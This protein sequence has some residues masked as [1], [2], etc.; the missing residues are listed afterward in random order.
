MVLKNV[1]LVGKLAIAFGLMMLVLVMVNV[2]T[3]MKMSRIK[4]TI[5]DVSKVRLPAVVAI[6]EIASKT[7]AFRILELRH[8]SADNLDQM[9]LLEQR[10]RELQFE[11]E[12]NQR[13][14]E[15]LL[16]GPRDRSLYR[17]VV[18]QWKSYVDLNKEFLKLS[19][20]GKKSDAA[21]LLNQEAGTLYE[22]L[23]NDLQA[24]VQMNR[25][26]SF[27]SAAEAGDLH[28]EIRFSLVALVLFSL[29]IAALA[30]WLLM[31]AIAEPVRRLDEA[32]RQ[33]ASG[34][35]QVML[36][37][38][39]RDEIGN[40]ARSFNLMTESIRKARSEN[41]R[42]DWIK[43][44]E[45]QLNERMRGDQDLLTL[46]RNVV[47]FLCQYTSAQ[48]GALYVWDAKAKELRLQASYAF[49]RRKNL[50]ASIKLGQ[51]LVGQAALERTI[52][53]ISDIPP[54]YV[55]VSSA[56]GEALP[57]QVLAS[58]FFFEEKLHGV[59]ELATLGEF[60]DK[61]LELLRIVMEN[62]AISFHSAQTNA[63]IK[64]LLSESQRQAAELQAQQQELKASNEELESQ[65]A[66]LKKSEAALQ[67][68]QDELR[69]TNEELEEKTNYLERQKREITQKNRALEIAREDI[70][71]KAKE[72]E[73]TSRY[74][75][76]FLANMSHEL[77][78]PLNSLLILARNLAENRGKNLN[79]EQI[80]SA[81]I[82]HQS[83][84]D[85]LQLINDILDLSKIEAG[86]M[87]I[88]LEQVYLEETRANLRNV[89]AHMV[90]EKGL[91]LDIEL[92]HGVP[93][94]ITTDKQRF[95]QVLKNLVS[96]AIKFTHA[97]GV[98]IRFFRPM[99][100]HRFR[101]P[102][103]DATK[104]LG[105]SVSDTGIG[106]PGPKQG[107][108]FEAF[109]QADGSTSRKYGGTG[110]GLSISRQIVKIFQGE[111][112]LESQEGKGSTFTVFLPVG[113]PEA[114]ATPEE[115]LAF[116]PAPER[117]ETRERP[118][119]P[120]AGSAGQDEGSGPVEEAPLVED[121]RR[122]IG[123]Q[124]RVILVVE[125]DKLFSKILYRQC[126][127][128]GFKCIVAARGE[129]G[130][131]LAEKHLP[132]AIILDLKLPGINGWKVLEA[133][134]ENPSVRHIPVHVMSAEEAKVDAL[135]KGAIGFLTK[136]IDKNQLE[137]AFTRLEGVI[138]KKIKDLLVVEDNANMRKAIGM[139]IGNGDVKTTE[140]ANGKE[141][142][143][144]LA[145]ESFDCV[146]L[147]LG[148]PDMD[149][150]E[151]LAQ[152]RARPGI[153][154]PPIIVY[155]GKDITAEQH[156]E[157]QKYADS[158]IIKGAK[159]EERLLDETALFLHRV[160]GNLPSDKQ[161]VIVNL[162]DKDS[163]F[164]GKRILLV[165]DDMR[166]VFA[167]AKVLKEKGMEVIKAENGFKALQAL[168][169]EPGIHLVLMDVMMPE[170]DGLETTRRIRSQPA[171]RK[172]PIIAVTAKAM[173]EDRDKCLAAG[174]SDYLPKPVDVDRL[175]SLMRVWL[176]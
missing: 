98:S 103:I 53:Q 79:P 106:I 41:E 161:Q 113:K 172:L 19:R 155:T 159:S 117:Q 85:L 148:L 36:Q 124:D 47:Q 122:D 134:K 141:A 173:K 5:D 11:V 95:E 128:K 38:D 43:S 27:E 17:G 44:G 123:P 119:L 72:L 138:N 34:Q 86:K 107:A 56:L 42:L 20:L 40:L 96:N 29:L 84:Q 174:A 25:Q 3:L 14:Y 135:K 87:S 4:D 167:L 6:T 142:L 145:S 164:K 140:A 93:P 80:E 12:N 71:K 105:I 118:G 21:Y 13:S 52:I 110:L 35:S 170:M 169:D 22:S 62:I 64:H 57:R 74:K 171:H 165:D 115:N 137:Q 149:G 90:A 49:N 162:H 176:Y 2:F 175:F 133:L 168:E 131:A 37:V 132:S 156:Q 28:G 24:L 75:S 1:K 111:I 18:E 99:A 121:D 10:M 120:E 143:E 70:E 100:S 112:Q 65:A 158:I 150:M 48:I 151:L 101:D 54:D 50:N 69:A 129:E 157:L 116:A 8:A 76:E 9:G 33:V 39:S 55:R 126:R 97:G 23:S 7:S 108:I 73:I 154:L 92:E 31:R 88:N 45:N 166:N 60:L 102:K 46:S 146:V 89:F 139:L 26:S 15:G 91:R 81:Q 94:S 109:Q 130:L 32:V 127:G 152:L 160:V 30:V 82:I 147:D 68:Q 153:E 83:G 16:S 63:Q 114:E 61:E 67:T 59:I 144:K 125:D 66:A 77:R 136:P 163:L 51:G 78:T 58:P 104:M